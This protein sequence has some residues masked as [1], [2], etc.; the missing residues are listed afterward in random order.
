[1][2]QPGWSGVAIVVLF[3]LLLEAALAS[4]FPIFFDEALFAS[5]A[6]L[7]VDHPTWHNA[8]L[9]VADNHGVLQRWL[10]AAEVR[11]GLDSLAAI[12]AV[13]VIAGAVTIV[14]VAAIARRIGREA[15]VFAAA[16]AAVMPA[17][18]VHS[19][20]GI[21]DPLALGAT[22][23]AVLLSLRV[24]ERPTVGRGA[25]AAMAIAIGVLTKQTGVLAVALLPVTVLT[26]RRCWPERDRPTRRWIAA[27]AVAVAGGV[28]AWGLLRLAPGEL[29]HIGHA[30]ARKQYLSLHQAVSAF[31]SQIRAN[32]GSFGADLLDYATPGLVVAA[33]M[34]WVETARRRT[35]VACLLALW[36]LAP[37]VAA[38]V[39]AK[40]AYPRYTLASYPPLAVLAGVGL[41]RIRSLRLGTRLPRPLLTALAVGVL[42]P[43]GV[44]DLRAVSGPNDASYPGLDDAQ[45]VSGFAAGTVWPEVAGAL[46]TVAATQHRDRVTVAWGGRG[47]G[48]IGLAAQIGDPVLAEGVI[49]AGFF[50]GRA[51]GRRYDFEPY[52]V[53]SNATFVVAQDVDLAPPP[54]DVL[55]RYRTVLIAERPHGGTKVA[56]FVHR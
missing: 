30:Y 45:Y 39:A 26:F 1:M 13:S 2:V 56:L 20:I 37:M 38:I 25:Q 3:Y 46:E 33:A 35:D 24:A 41:S 40:F 18:V 47:V 27:C 44:F 52:S 48:P 16:A 51:K 29:Q 10:V 31:P 22:S 54:A 12:R 43:A 8:F 34:G 9:A 6:Q 5:E 4:R 19:A 49:N 17:L 23:L 42:V 11:A 15:M 14:S 32:F 50:S 21:A 7:L 53:D 36:A 28:L 55:K